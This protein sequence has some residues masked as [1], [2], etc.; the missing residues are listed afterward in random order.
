MQKEIKKRKEK[1]IKIKNKYIK[2][3]FFIRDTHGPPYFC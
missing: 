1:E 2:L 3:L